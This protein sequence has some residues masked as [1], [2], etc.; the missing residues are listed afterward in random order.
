MHLDQLPCASFDR[1]G[2]LVVGVVRTWACPSVDGEM[3]SIC[4]ITITSLIDILSCLS[5]LCCP[6]LGQLLRAQTVDFPAVIVSVAPE[7]GINKS[8]PC[9]LQCYQNNLG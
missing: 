2:S 5:H 8:L 4:R 1:C 3:I 7:T 9:C 6:R